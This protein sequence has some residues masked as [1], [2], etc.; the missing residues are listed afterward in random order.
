MGYYENQILPRLIDVVL[1]RQQF[2]EVRSRVTAGLEG[3]VVE[4]GFGSGLNVPHYPSE[5][6]KLKAIDPATLGRKLAAKRVA[7]SPVDIE[8]IELDGQALPLE[9]DSIDHVLITWTMC[10]IADIEGA[11]KEMYRILRPGGQLH[12]VEHGHSPDPKVAHWQDILTPLQRRI[13]GGCHLNRPIDQLISQAGFNIIKM[14]N[15]YMKAPKPIG[16]IFE[17]VATK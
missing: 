17:G 10:T 7:N 9:T 8:Y 14:D 12:F 6:N 2:S 5:I 16:Y 11:L 4:V 13:S 3:D 1:S 15:F